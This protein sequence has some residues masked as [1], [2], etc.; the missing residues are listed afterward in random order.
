[1]MK[2]PARGK[3]IP[4]NFFSQSRKKLGRPPSSYSKNGHGNENYS[5]ALTQLLFQSEGETRR[6]VQNPCAIAPLMYW[7]QYGLTSI[8]QNSRSFTTT[9]AIHTTSPPSGNNVGALSNYADHCSVTSLF[10]EISSRY[11]V[12]ERKSLTLPR[13]KSLDQDGS[14]DRSH[15]KRVSFGKSTAVLTSEF[16]MTYLSLPEKFVSARKPI[17]IVKL[18]SGMQEEG[19]EREQFLRL[20][21]GDD[22]GVNH[23]ALLAA[24]DTIPA[25]VSQAGEIPE[26]NVH[27]LRE[28]CTPLY[29]KIFFYILGSAN[30]DL[31]VAFLVKLRKDVR[32]VIHNYK[33]IDRS[34]YGTDPKK[35]SIKVLLPRLQNLEK[36]LQTILTSLFR[37]G[38]LQ[39]KQITY[40]NTP[41]S[42]IEQIA[43]KEAV[44]PL[45]S[46]Q[47]LR[48]RLGRGRR[49][50]AFFHPALPNTPLVFVHVAL[51]RHIP[52]TMDD[53]Q[54]G[55]KDILD[56]SYS[57]SDA[58]CAT[59][60]SITNTEPG[61]AGVDLGN[62]LIKSVVQV[63][64]E[65]FPNK[66]KTF[67][68]LSPIPNFKKWLEGKLVRYHEEMRSKP[69]STEQSLDN[70]N[71]TKNDNVL[72]FVDNN[73]FTDDELDK[74]AKIFPTSSE[75]VLALL[76]SLND[77]RWEAAQKGAHILPSSIDLAE[78]LQ[79][80]LLKFAAYYL[81]VESRH[82]RP[83]CPVAKFHIR[84]G[85]EMY[86]LNFLADRS[87][88]GLRNSCGIMI[89]YRYV[90]DEIEENHLKY[91]AVGA[92][93][94]REGVNLW[95]G[96]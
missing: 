45:Q 44:H 95:L 81:T 24:I 20:L 39:L 77:N 70:T 33:L 86:R 32:D 14:I 19:C 80:F 43:F 54:N 63:L 4:F 71:D 88:K 66:L 25:H 78:K 65:E 58:T 48:M 11:E 17:S 79:P 93:N 10:I 13:T 1:M 7:R 94:V 35:D 61:L 41:A 85:A 3:S 82:G 90:L 23:V 50:F 91:E 74:L 62:H 87:S 76:D 34:Y 83:L 5:L 9:P 2:L 92:I 51:L 40:H 31:G 42:I 64:K 89:N 57:E 72:K 47:D 22:Y 75:P 8:H 38:V 67:C 36:S 29:E 12:S 15:G 21:S 59:F 96:K 18:N 37:P 68:T 55:T 30:D 52:E 84:N 46:L 60:Y 27:R 49:C 56:G 28:I 73:L 16:C 69:H 26:N 6:N 53:I